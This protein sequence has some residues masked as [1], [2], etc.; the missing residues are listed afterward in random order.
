MT[1]I[2]GFGSISQRHVSA[3]P[4]LDPQH[5]VVGNLPS[6]TSSSLSYSYFFFPLLARALAAACLAASCPYTTDIFKTEQKFSF[7]SL[8]DPFVCIPPTSSKQ[9]KHFRISAFK[10]FAVRIRTRISHFASLLIRILA[11]QCAIPPF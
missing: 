2:A 4:D 6:S 9:K 10:I 5:C 8:S 1:K 3:D 7:F 11:V